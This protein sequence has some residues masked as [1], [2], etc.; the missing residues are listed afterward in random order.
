MPVAQDEV[1]VLL[2]LDKFLCN[3][4]RTAGEVPNGERPSRV[5]GG[6]RLV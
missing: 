6:A 2:V 4:K 3:S 1:V 5:C